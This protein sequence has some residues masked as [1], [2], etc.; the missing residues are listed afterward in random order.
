MKDMR[1][2]ERHRRR[3]KVQRAL[4]RVVELLFQNAVDDIDPDRT[5]ALLAWQVVRKLIPFIREAVPGPADLPSEG[6]LSR[7]VYLIEDRKKET[8]AR[9]Q[10][11]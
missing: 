4:A 8:K 1:A 9:R 3:R 2:K 10:R 11:G 6:N 5:T 7:V